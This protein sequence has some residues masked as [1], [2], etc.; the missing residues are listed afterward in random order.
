MNLR[1][2]MGTAAAGVALT[3]SL[4][5]TAV[6][7]DPFE[8]LE[9]ITPE[10]LFKGIIR[11]DDVTLLFRHLRESMAAAARGE[12]ARESEA[13]NRRAEQIQREVAVRGGALAGVA[14]SAFESAIKQMVRERLGEFS[15]SVPR[16]AP[17]PRF[18]AK[19]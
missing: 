14:L 11:E 12:E 4:P 8:R 19:D 2:L 16:S 17:Y 5:A 10:M 18:G 6:D 13:L 7:N 3:L 9:S 1:Y 15:S